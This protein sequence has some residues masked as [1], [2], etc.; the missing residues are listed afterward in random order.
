MESLRFLRPVNIHRII[1]FYPTKEHTV[2]FPGGQQ[3]HIVIGCH[4]KIYSILKHSNCVISFLHQSGFSVLIIGDVS[5]FFRF[6]VFHPFAAI[7]FHILTVG[8]E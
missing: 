6:V 4:I 8:S 2:F 3:L 5:C 7:P 1:R